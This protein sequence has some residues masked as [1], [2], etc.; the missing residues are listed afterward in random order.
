MPTTEEIA[1]TVVQQSASA[2]EVAAFAESLAD[3]A[4]AMQR[5][6]WAFKI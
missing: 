2:Q 5:S 6:N 4:D 1:A 3:I